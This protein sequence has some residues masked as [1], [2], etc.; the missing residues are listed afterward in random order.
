MRP[1][2][3][4]MFD[5]KVLALALAVL[6]IFGA[7]A[8]TRI[9]SVLA[10][11]TA[12][13][14]N[15][16]F[17]DSFEEGLHKSWKN[18]DKA[19]NPSIEVTDGAMQV[20]WDQAATSTIAYGY[21]D[22]SDEWD[23][24]SVS[25][26]ICFSEDMTESIASGS[27]VSFVVRRTGNTYY[28]LRFATCA[29]SISMELYQYVNNE[30]TLVQNYINRFIEDKLG[31]N[32]KLT[33]GQSYNLKVM[34]KSEHIYIYLDNILLGRY[35]DTSD[36]APKK[37][38]AGM[39]L[40]KVSA[41]IDN[42]TVSEKG[43]LNIQ[44]VEVE[45]LED[46]VFEI[47][48]GF[49][50][51]AYNYVVHCY[52][53]DGTVISEI[54]T[55]DMLSSYDNQKVGSQ[56]ITITAQGVTEDAVV[57]VLRRDD[58]ITQLENDLEELNV[59][60]LKLENVDVVKE[61][62]ARY[63]AL[64]AYE[65]SK[66]SQTAIANVASTRTKIELLQYP[67]LE[68][69]DVLYHTTF[70]SEEE[71]D[72]YEWYNGFKNGRGEWEILNG[73]YRVEQKSHGISNETTRVLKNA[74]GEIKSVSA[75]MQLLTSYAY[76]GV[77]LN[78]SMEGQY[79]A[80]VDMASYNSSGVLI[81]KF[82]VLKGGEKLVSEKLSDYRIQLAEGDWFNIRLTYNEGL[83]SAYVNDTLVYS[84]DMG[85]D[86]TFSEGRA[87]VVI[88][89]GNG[90]FDNF[91]V[92]GVAKDI[93][94]SV[95]D[96]V[97][98]EYQ[99]DFED[100]IS[101]QNP[102]YWVKETTAD[103]WKVASSDGN[104][105]YGTAGSETYTSSWLH[106][107]E[108][109]PTVTMDFMYDSEVSAAELGFYVRMAPETAYV[110]VGYDVA[111]QLWYVI[112]TEAERDSDVN[113]TYSDKECALE[114]NTWHSIKIEC[115]D[116]YITVTVDSE[117]I[118]ARHKVS[119]VGYG[120]IG[121]YCQNTKFY[122]DNV[123]CE[124]PNG[125]VAQ[126]GLIEYT[127]SEAFYDA[128]VDVTV[129]DENNIIGLGIY[130]SYL[131]TDG[132]ESFDI[133]GGVSA[134]EADIV[135]QYEELT[136]KSGYQS[137]LRT[138]DGTLL[139]IHNS[140][141][142]VKKSTDNLDTWT[143]IGRV[144][145]K[146]YLKDALGRRNVTS[147][148]N[149]LTEVQ[150][151]DGN[152][153]LFMPVAVCVYPDEL[154]T[155]V[156][157]H[158]TEVYYSDDDGAT[159]KKSKNDTRDIS[160]NYEEL[161]NTF[162]WSESKII[163]C[164]DGSLR[165]YMT[166]AKYGCMQYS[167][168]YDGGETWEGQYSVPEMQTAKSSFNIIQDKD[169]TYYLVWVN[170]NPVR[171]GA[172]FSR[173]RL[174][175][176]RS[177]DGMNWEFLC[178]LERM[179]E[180]VY[181]NDMTVTTPL[182]QL[183]DPSIEVD[184]DYV[185]VT[186]GRSGGT[187]NN[188]NRSSGST[189][190]YH[191]ALRPRMIR[192][193]KSKLQ[194][195][196][197]DASTISDMLFV[198]SMEVTEPI[199][200]RFEYGDT[201]AYLGGK[202]M[203][204][205]MDGTQF[206]V[207]M[208]QL[209][210]AEEPDIYTPGTQDVVLRN[211]NGTPAVYQVSFAGCTL[212]SE[213]FENGAEDWGHTTATIAPDSDK[214]GVI[215]EENGNKAYQL[216]YTRAG[217]PPSGYFRYKD[218]ILDIASGFVIEQDVTLYKNDSG[219][220]SYIGILPTHTASGTRCRY[221]LRIIPHQDGCK[222]QLLDVSNGN[223]STQKDITANN[224]IIIEDNALA[225]MYKE[226]EFTYR[227]RLKVKQETDG[228]GNKTVSFTVWVNDNDAVMLPTFTPV[229]PTFTPNELRLYLYSYSGEDVYRAVVDNIRVYSLTHTLTYVAEAPADHQNH[230]IGEHY[231][232]STCD[233]IFADKEGLCQIDLA[234]L[235]IDPYCDV[236]LDEDFTFED[237]ET[238]ALWDPTIGKKA[239]ASD[240]GVVTDAEGNDV[241]QLQY[242]RGTAGACTS[243]VK[244]NKSLF[245]NLHSFD[246]R[247][248][249]TLEK[250][251]NNKWSYIGVRFRDS[252]TTGAY[253]LRFEATAQGCKVT[254]FDE[255]NTSVS[256]PSYSGTVQSDELL[257]MYNTSS[258]YGFD[259]RIVTDNYVDGA[260]SKKIKFTVY[261]DEN[262][263]LTF[264]VALTDPECNPTAFYLYLYAGSVTG[265]TVYRAFVDDVQVYNVSH[266][267][268]YVG[269]TNPTDAEEGNIAHYK[270]TT[271][272]KR[273]SDKA[274]SVEL[275]AKELTIPR[276]PACTTIFKDDFSTSTAKDDW[277]LS[278]CTVD[279]GTG[280]LVITSKDDATSA[281]IAGKT[282]GQGLLNKETDFGF[283]MDATIYKDVE[284][285]CWSYMDV[286][287]RNSSSKDRYEISI[288]PTATG[289]TVRL[290]YY[291]SDNSSYRITQTRT[292]ADKDFATS[293]VS[294]TEITYNLHVVVD[295]LD[296][297]QV[298]IHVYVDNHDAEVFEINTTSICHPTAVR[299]CLSS[300][301][302][303]VGHKVTVDNMKA[304]KTT[305]DSVTAVE[306]TPS[307][308]E[309][310]GVKAHHKCSDCGKKFMDEAAMVEASGTALA[311][312]KL[313]DVLCQTR[314]NQTNPDN[315]DIRFVVYVNDYTKYRGVEFTITRGG[316]MGVA[317]TKKVYQQIYAAGKPYTTQAVYGVTTGHFATF[318]LANNTEDQLEEKMT[319][320]VKWIALDGTTKQETREVTVIQD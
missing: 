256:E 258:Q 92:R 49:D 46:N 47:Y 230:G 30:R 137:V 248:N 120:R 60:N 42:Y 33:N 84:D 80:R 131:S 55:P 148:N 197:W 143:D 26:D 262:I 117:V 58:Y 95:V 195:R 310:A 110:K 111:K 169:G 162:E 70:T 107:F 14:T 219:K 124:F 59:S 175:L 50:I 54:L 213:D 19:T 166:R 83:L 301:S 168:S 45:G 303:S 236:L 130:G 208:S 11:D 189:L 238:A 155:S 28:D 146:T 77:M 56:S 306:A 73:A 158:Y 151:Q 198:K 156:S 211:S 18:F 164:T 304:Y 39:K 119:Q 309:V 85:E 157:G 31:N 244:Y 305:H 109:D 257:S 104:I 182:M 210:L 206:S 113:I 297:S 37:G 97:P 302:G 282:G 141:Y 267:M 214:F 223:S 193:E 165:M 105:Y 13:D 12:S 315:T 220:W 271:C 86:A 287:F 203:A 128:G 294:G 207:D 320:T 144:V 239:V 319:V 269:K 43:P 101:G 69:Y 295:T 204:T 172:T 15:P 314:K 118:F 66:L 75:D 296:A 94:A 200:T 139:V 154:A 218:K 147:H 123:T 78:V 135:S 138:H 317:S 280:A 126:D 38:R 71:C 249:V 191:N 127:M 63:D 173:T 22:G 221:D 216:Q 274:C 170:N 227:L 171:I 150:L 90:K 300:T 266:T 100:E 121:V 1:I 142:V 167:V 21:V 307:T 23:D 40:A 278:G 285:D 252:D 212:V 79:T 241:Y 136:G 129:L 233:E 53:A 98:T 64:S 299:V 174:S 82:Q 20:E 34:C 318:I 76:G 254:L 81:P 24:Y 277:T 260:G 178:D 10:V 273:F 222:V 32:V 276:L 284:T 153:R 134:D 250:S 272:D 217:D 115:S 35:T 125:D 187:D 225:Q 259:V 229:D 51:E 177:I 202:V 253:E 112:D 29:G 87:G 65:I 190:N 99:D 293:F 263:P 298:K 61:I 291:D 3:R 6:M 275:T 251:T 68:S 7:I 290:Y 255:T 36:T 93:P 268:Q 289:Y 122:I 279:D 88:W 224:P 160:F 25:A 4:K 140:D 215:T 188:L 8:D 316:K 52:D 261:I 62:L 246:Y 199:K 240:F 5:K 179:S 103:D 132:G 74:Y 265:D 237:D 2:M 194:A 159:W 205:R 145:P 44:K 72:D 270:C 152:W 163:Q 209:I 133:I 17:Y 96:P 226:E 185:Y 114:E 196:A 102:D 106:V 57:K 264:D 232:C 48:E 281:Y 184:E 286:W 41:T 180:E 176:A 9:L 149:S 283:S 242:T 67:E 311:Y 201:F 231:A 27:Y 161:G 243:N 89:N 235:Q 116:R 247:M 192:I 108:K 313:S 234:D 16:L 183:V 292:V 186:V 308:N 181:G 228:E 245:K 288:I 312:W 91:T